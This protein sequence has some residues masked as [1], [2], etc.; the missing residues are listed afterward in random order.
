MSQTDTEANA[1][2]PESSTR[3]GPFRV[4]APKAGNMRD[5]G[6]RLVEMAGPEYGEGIAQ[7][8]AA[9]RG[10][11]GMSLL[12]HPTEK[13]R[14]AM[15]GYR[16][17]AAIMEDGTLHSAEVV[18]MADPAGFFVDGKVRASTLDSLQWS[19]EAN[20]LIEG[21]Q[22]P[23][24]SLSVGS[25]MDFSGQNLMAR[26]SHAM[27][28]MTF[29]LNSKFRFGDCP[30]FL[31][32]TNTAG[33]I[34]GTLR[35][36]T[37]EVEN[38]FF[39][40]WQAYSR[41]YLP[42]RQGFVSHLDARMIA[43]LK[44]AG[45]GEIKSYNWLIGKG[46]NNED[47][48]DLYGAVRLKLTQT[49]PLLMPTFMDN[50]R[51][52]IQDAID[53][54]VDMAMDEAMKAGA[55]AGSQVERAKALLDQS[56]ENGDFALPSLR[57]GVD[58][59]ARAVALRFH[60]DDGI[61]AA[62]RGITVAEIGIKAC[63]SDHGLQSLFAS[64]GLLSVKN[65]PVEDRKGTLKDV[66][67]KSRL[68]AA[69]SRILNDVIMLEL[70]QV[71]GAV[72][73]DDVTKAIRR[74][75]DVSGW[76]YANITLGLSQVSGQTS[77]PS[78]M[79]LISN[80]R[81][82]DEVVA[83]INGIYEKGREITKRLQM[84]SPARVKSGE[85]L[86]WDVMIPQPL[87]K[88]GKFRATFLSSE[89]EVRNAALR[90]DAL[91][92]TA[93]GRAFTTATNYVLLERI[94]GAG[95]AAI[96]V[97]AVNPKA[98]K[99]S[100]FEEYYHNDGESPD[101]RWIV[102]R[103]D[104]GDERL[105]VNAAIA[106]FRQHFLEDPDAIRLE[107]VEAEAIA[108][109]HLLRDRLRIPE[110]TENGRSPF[111]N[112]KF[113]AAV[114]GGGVN[115]S[116]QT[117][118]QAWAAIAAHCPEHLRG[119]RSGLEAIQALRDFRVGLRSRTASIEDEMA[120]SAPAPSV[121]LSRRVSTPASGSDDEDTPAPKAA[122]SRHD[123]DEAPAAKR[124][125]QGTPLHVM[126]SALR[127]RSEEQSLLERARAASDGDDLSRSGPEGGRPNSPSPF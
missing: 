30:A 101:P 78:L 26:W 23:S 56:D 111:E 127:E 54:I 3:G 73:Q 9:W 92:P 18:H 40:A 22:K 34:Q 17:C 126:L 84:T 96:G 79:N 115:V 63:L 80:Q 99:K 50:S 7:V 85:E 93:S 8:V 76:V 114:Y 110:T 72:S 103:W 46:V 113:L 90:I 55:E 106:E 37:P 19:D 91:M 14:L 102:G 89:V 107:R 71:S 65:L 12:Y 58:A 1:A 53:A 32:D 38:L 31:E 64:R 27:R 2:N 59:V 62:L 94:D 10:V 69:M 52:G 5:F 15:R 108:R 121:I 105:E 43:A 119:Y 60:V 88:L 87:I 11:H 44:D 42:V 123:G 39:D 75:Q 6:D 36:M 77:V 81:P 16:F 4:S 109:S 122:P 120:L 28:V 20:F 112:P 51:F 82:F 47:H 61:I 57:A 66:F 70:P 48:A 41:G 100:A 116:E 118:L 21:E 29:L 45:M 83:L 74:L 33:G 13:I 97:I 124:E 117:A 49:Y 67:Q 35:R 24:S 86:S 68:E 98:L 125:D 25:W 95:N 104:K